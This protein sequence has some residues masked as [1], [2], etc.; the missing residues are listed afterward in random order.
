[1]FKSLVTLWFG[2]RKLAASRLKEAKAL[3]S[4]GRFKD[5]CYAYAAALHLGARDRALCARKIAQ[6]W[7]DHGPF[8]FSDIAKRYEEEKDPCGLAGHEAAM[9]KMK[10]IIEDKRRAT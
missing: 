9:A 5:A 1:M 10:R 2:N 4:E 3:E 6:L 8:D 7:L